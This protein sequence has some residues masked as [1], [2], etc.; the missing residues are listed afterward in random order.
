MI[1][2]VFVALASVTFLTTVVAVSPAA[3]QTRE[4]VTMETMH[5]LSEVPV[6]GTT[7]DGG[8]FKG[9]LDV[10][11]LAVR[12]GQLVVLGTLSGALRD[13]A[14]NIIKTIRNVAAEL[15]LSGISGTCQI[16]HLVIGPI[17]LDLLGLVVHINRI[18][19][20]ITAVSGPGNLLGN[21]LC[22]I[23][24]LLNN[25][26]PVDILAQAINGLLRLL[27]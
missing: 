21:L 6:N 2:S 8:T 13:S 17:D 25:N 20:D 9:S 11:R 26:S 15:A 24:N 14:G 23:A 27:N 4:K 16:L 3:A 22:A 5:L 10:A 12:D 19:V 7:P 18:V 1:R